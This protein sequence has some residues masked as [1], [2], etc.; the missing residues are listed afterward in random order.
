MEPTQEP[1]A[2]CPIKKPIRIN[3]VYDSAIIRL[4]EKF[5]GDGNS[6]GW[7]WQFDKSYEWWFV[8]DEKPPFEVGDKI[9]ITIR[10]ETK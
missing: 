7:F 4:E 5:D 6:R 8:S 3:F 1:V 10:K 2:S 9:T